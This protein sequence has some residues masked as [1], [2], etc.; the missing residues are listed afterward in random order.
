LKGCKKDASKRNRACSHKMTTN[1]D[2]HEESRRE[3]PQGA[4]ELPYVHLLRNGAIG[5]QSGGFNSSMWKLQPEF[6]RGLDA[7]RQAPCPSL[8]DRIHSIFAGVLNCF[9]VEG[10]AQAD[11]PFNSFFFFCYFTRSIVSSI[12]FQK[13]QRVYEGLF[14]FSQLKDC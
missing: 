13:H 7:T 2:C 11:A 10:A 9:D 6:G 8:L 12:K 3:V 5:R 14:L 4:G 1:W